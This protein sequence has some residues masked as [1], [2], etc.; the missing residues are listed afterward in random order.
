MGGCLMVFLFLGIFLVLGVVSMVLNFVYGLWRT[1]QRLKPGNNASNQRGDRQQGRWQEG[2]R[3]TGESD[4]PRENA[5]AK[6]AK[7]NGKIFQQSEGEYVD[8]E[9]VKDK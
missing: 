8:F 1:T 6:T 4:A 5:N 9:E 7:Q 2:G 3:A